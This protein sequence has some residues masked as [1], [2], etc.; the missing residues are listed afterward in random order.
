V[1]LAE[2]V[3]GPRIYEPINPYMYMLKRRQKSSFCLARSRVRHVAK[4]N[5][6]RY[7]VFLGGQLKCD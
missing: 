6:S 3:C 1:P 4:K 7:S 2:R 5:A